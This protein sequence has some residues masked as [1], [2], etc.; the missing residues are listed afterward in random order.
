MTRTYPGT[1]IW[2]K[3][4]ICAAVVTALA[5]WVADRQDRR[6]N[7]RRLSA[8]ASQIAGRDVRVK[9]PG[10]IGRLF[11]WDIVEGS[12][13]FRRRRQARRRD[14]DPQAA[15]RRARRARGGAKAERAH[16]R[17][18]HRDGGRRARA[19]VMAPAGRDRRGGDRV[20]L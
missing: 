3:L 17:A 13:R 18:R 20:P 5:W 1:P 7:E 11:G 15:V 6:S 10:P 19:R 14:E 16:A 9:C 12:V 4:T 8:I 2:V